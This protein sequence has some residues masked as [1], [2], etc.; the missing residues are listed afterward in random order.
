MILVTE[1]KSTLSDK[2]MSWIAWPLQH[3]PNSYHVWITTL[4]PG[5]DKNKAEKLVMLLGK[6]NPKA[7]S[8][9]I[10]T[11]MTWRHL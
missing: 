1:M 10:G 5:K 6:H 9:T 4:G 2:Y 7:G 8:Q 3:A 11:G